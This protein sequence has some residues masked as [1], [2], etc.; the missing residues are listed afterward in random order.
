M[1]ELDPPIIGTNFVNRK[2]REKFSVN[3]NWLNWFEIEKSKLE[4][5]DGSM[6]KS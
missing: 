4:E 6:N 2:K 3:L 1:S 5:I